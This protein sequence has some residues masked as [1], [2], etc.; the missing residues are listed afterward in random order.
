[1]FDIF[2]N[3]NEINFEKAH[4][5]IFRDGEG[6]YSH[7]QWYEKDI[8]DVTAAVHKYNAQLCKDE[9]FTSAEICMD[10]LVREICAQWK[11]TWPLDTLPSRYKKA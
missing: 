11:K 7:F 9:T 1:M 5:V 10:K 4:L 2:G 6:R 3:K 8:K